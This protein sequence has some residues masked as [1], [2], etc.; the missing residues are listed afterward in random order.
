MTILR[1]YQKQLYDA[2]PIKLKQHKSVIVQAPPGSGKSVIIAH[3]VL[4]IIAAGK[5]PL[6]LT[7]REKIHG[8]LIEHCSAKSIDA[9]V[10]FIQ[11]EI[12]HCF[13]A[14][15]QTLLRR[16]FILSQL[17]ALEH[18]I[19]IIADECR[20]GN[21]C[22]VFDMLPSAFRIGFDA[23]PAY[24]WAK[25]LPK[26]YKELIPGPQISELQKE[27]NLIEFEYYEMQTKLDGLKRGSNGEYTE[28][29]QD[30]VFSKSI[31]YDGLVTE[32]HNFNGRYKKGLIFCASIK[33]CEK[34]YT[35][36]TE[37]GFNPVRYHS[38][39]S[40]A[41]GS[42]QLA[43][44]TKL[45][46]SSLLISVSALSEGF[47]YPPLDFEI[48]YRATTSLPLFIQM[49]MRCSRPSPNKSKS[50]ILDFGGNHTRHKSMYMDRDWSVLW[51][52]PPIV[53]K[54]AGVANIKY[55]PMCEF[56]MSALS[57]SCPNCGYIY[58]EQEIKL[59]E[60]ELIRVSEEQAKLKGR[61]VSTLSP[62]ELALYAKTNSKSKF[63]TRIAKARDQQQ[64][65]F[66]VAFARAMGYKNG[67]LYHQSLSTRPNERIE[68]TDIT[69]R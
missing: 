50:I 47:D 58:P 32:L 37:A 2:I 62:S 5:I 19:V 7:H 6:V 67:W 48:L 68:F 56:I 16:P 17:K 9:S 30:E 3:T 33:S 65:G 69:L 11:I 20:N 4:R 25:F 26:Y 55:C 10:K 28:Q 38:G 34:L 40:K 24:K 12:G 14:M 13:V 61:R 54:S 44:F 18:L 1:P 8:Q 42:H 36:L 59:K 27:G 63:A 23:T 22:S 53:R 41:E 60:G 66:L 49:G 45:N 52:A 31:L 35:D 64:P 39:L 46:Q 29:S 15:N 43:M 51:K 57:K 21:F